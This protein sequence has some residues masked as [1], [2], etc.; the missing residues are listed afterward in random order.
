MRL[1][2]QGRQWRWR[3]RLLGSYDGD[4]GGGDDGN[5]DGSN[6]EGGSDSD[7]REWHEDGGHVHAQAIVV[8]GVPVGRGEGW[9]QPERS[10]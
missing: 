10:Q 9:K 3:P 1:A 5:G 7:S 6:G 2:S 4:G 8:S